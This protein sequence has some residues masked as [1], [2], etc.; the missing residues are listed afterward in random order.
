MLDS[1]S[2]PV[3]VKISLDCLQQLGVV[4]AR[5]IQYLKLCDEYNI[6]LDVYHKCWGVDTFEANR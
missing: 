6:T 1:F 5:G 3:R 4:R 2:F